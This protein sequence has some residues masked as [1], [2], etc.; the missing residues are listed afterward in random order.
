[1]KGT[2]L[3]AL[4]F[5]AGDCALGQEAVRPDILRY[6]GPV[7][8]LASPRT[9]GTDQD[10]LQRVGVQA[11]APADS[12]TGYRYDFGSNDTYLRYSTTGGNQLFIAHPVLPSGARISGVEFGLCDTDPVAEIFAQILTT[13]N[14][15]GTLQVVDIVGTSGTPGCAP[16]FVDLSAANLVVDNA[17]MQILLNIVLAS[18]DTT[19]SFAGATVFYRLQ[20]S[21]APAL[22]SFNDV[23]DTHPFFQFIEA[24]KSSGITGGCQVAPPLYCP[25][26]FVTRGQ[27]AGFLAKALGLQFP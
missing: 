13:D 27:M 8:A 4:V 23:P 6:P 19:Q 9:F 21:P 11:F 10:S 25:D 16:V 7:R 3:S 17:T 22:A 18:G 2:V 5:L 12:A 14:L 1:M 24:L 20:V 26:N 15:G